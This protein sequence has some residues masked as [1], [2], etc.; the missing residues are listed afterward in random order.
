MVAKWFADSR[1]QQTGERLDR[2]EDPFRCIPMNDAALVYPMQ[3][4][5]RTCAGSPNSWHDRHRRPPRMLRE[6]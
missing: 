1:D 5:P 3:P 4:S 6:R 2:L